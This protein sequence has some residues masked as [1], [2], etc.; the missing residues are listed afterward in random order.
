MNNISI[1]GKWLKGSDV[2]GQYIEEGNKSILNIL[3]KDAKI[4][5]AH[6][7]LER[8]KLSEIPATKELLK[9]NFFSKERQIFSFDALLTQV[10]ILNEI[11]KT[12]F[13]NATAT[14]VEDYASKT[15]IFTGDNISDIKQNDK[16]MSIIAGGWIS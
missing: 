6:K 14:A 5:I 3:D 8:G 9:D 13:G 11:N 7:F 15:K 1:D 12:N 4:I 16:L 2:N 10:D